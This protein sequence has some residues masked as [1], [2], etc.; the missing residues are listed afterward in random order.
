MASLTGQTLIDLLNDDTLSVADA[1]NILDMSI[2]CLNL[3][4]TEQSNLSGTTPTK[5]RSVTSKERGAIL[6][7]A[8]QIYLSIYRVGSSSGAGGS[9]SS[10]YGLGGMSYSQSTSSNITS[11]LMNNPDVR[12]SVKEAAERLMEADWSQAFI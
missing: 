4:G 7:V 2:D 10:S 1:E 9:S 11:S 12:I 6:L 3:Y 8:N 5:T